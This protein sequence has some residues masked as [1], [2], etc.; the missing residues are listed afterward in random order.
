MNLLSVK[1]MLWGD[2]QSEKQ[3][4]KILRK[5]FCNCCSEEKIKYALKHPF[6]LEPP[7]VVTERIFRPLIKDIPKIFIK[8]SKDMTATLKFQNQMIKNLRNLQKKLKKNLMNPLKNLR[9]KNQLKSKL[10]KN[11]QRIK[12]KNLLKKLLNLKNQR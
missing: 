6:K 7:A 5:Y 8:L 10:P 3:H 9:R 11:Y 4:E 12:K 2:K 1:L